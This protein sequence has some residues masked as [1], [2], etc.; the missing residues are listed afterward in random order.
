MRYIWLIPALPAMGAAINGLVGVR[1]FSRKAAG[2][3]ACTTMTAA[4][5]L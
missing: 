4:L 3:V 2:V 5:G 1:L